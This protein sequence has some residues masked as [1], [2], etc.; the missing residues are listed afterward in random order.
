MAEPHEILADLLQTVNRGIWDNIRGVVHEHRLPVVSMVV[1]RQI[2]HEPGITIGELSRRTGVA[3]SH[4]SNTVESLAQKGLIEKRP[5]PADQR[6][7]RV[8]P[9][10][11]AEARH[12]Q[13]HAEIKSQLS[14][15]LASVPPEKVAALI[16]G[17]Q[18]LKAALEERKGAN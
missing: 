7:V 10:E 17:L 14:E 2:G 5:D 16:D 13:I 1:M 6:L 15:V 3:K 8:F 4:I 18:A 9:T 11:Q 12:R